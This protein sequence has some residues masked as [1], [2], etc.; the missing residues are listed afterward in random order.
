M[1]GANEPPG[2][3]STLTRA[4]RSAVTFAEMEQFVREIESRPLDRF[5]DDLPSLMALPETKYHLFAMTLRKR[6]RAVTEAEAAEIVAR[7]G[8]LDS[9]L[10]D[11]VVR[12]RCAAILRS[13]G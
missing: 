10:P 12:A 4:A 9:G 1:P 7:I 5:L 3:D 13:L 2:D 8:R 6:I 11:P